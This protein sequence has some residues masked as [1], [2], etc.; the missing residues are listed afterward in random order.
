[1]HAYPGPTYL[2]AVS[3][4]VEGQLREGTRFRD[5]GRLSFASSFWVQIDEQDPIPGFFFS[6]LLQGGGRNTR[7]R[8][9]IGPISKRAIS[10][11]QV[12]LFG[13]SM[14]QVVGGRGAGPRQDSDT[15]EVDLFCSP[16][17]S[18]DAEN[19]WEARGSFARSGVLDY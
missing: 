9:R 12:R 6:F 11:C 7:K 1:M 14:Y 10:S 5:L 17:L 4:R 2:H 8:K 19:N 13:I 16:A 15:A 3:S 18:G